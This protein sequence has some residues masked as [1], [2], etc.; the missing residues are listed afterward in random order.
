MDEK[1]Q[2]RLRL[3]LELFPNAAAQL[4]GAL[5]NIEFAVSRIVPPEAR[6]FNREMDRNAALLYQSYYRA[7]PAGR[8][9]PGP[10]GPG[11]DGAGGRCVPQGGGHGRAAGAAPGV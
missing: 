6:D 9:A 4:R 11:S 8:Q 3:L 5:G 7:L 2:E 1:D 10:G